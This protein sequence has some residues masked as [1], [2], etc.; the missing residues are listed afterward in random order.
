MLPIA[1]ISL[2]VVSVCSMALQ[3]AAPEG[4]YMAGN[5]PAAYDTG[6]DKAATYNGL[7]SAYLKSNQPAIEGFGTL[8]Q[9]FKADQY[10]GKRVRF[11]AFVRSED[12][13]DWAGLWMR[14]DKGTGASM[15]SLAFDNMQDRPVKGTTGWQNYEVVLDVASDATGVFFGILLSGTGSVWLNSAKIEV[16]PTTVPVTGHST[17]TP[18]DTPQNLDFQK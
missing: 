1:R 9:D 16:V 8:M 7:A 3:A 4:W 15:K 11:S 6:V 5:K 12:V 17:R 13:K 2:S 14:V 18:S 10:Q